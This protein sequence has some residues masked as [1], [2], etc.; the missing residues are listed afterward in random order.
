MSG[1]EQ[2]FKAASLELIEGRKRK[3][4][5]D[6][7]VNDTNQIKQQIENELNDIGGRLERG[8]QSMQSKMNNVRSVRGEGFDE[9]PENL[10]VLAEVESQKNAFL[11]NALS[12]LINNQVLNEQAPE[13]IAEI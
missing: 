11:M 5:I 3:Q 9:S 12:H 1:L 13:L 6:R 8:E 10:M 4:E 7:E 2:S